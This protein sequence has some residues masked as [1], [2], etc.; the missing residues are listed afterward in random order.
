[1]RTPDAR[2][3]LLARANRPIRQQALYLTLQERRRRV[4][5]TAIERHDQALAT[6]ALVEL[7]ALMGAW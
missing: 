6:A 7:G 4:L 3:A 5:L 2:L 1:M